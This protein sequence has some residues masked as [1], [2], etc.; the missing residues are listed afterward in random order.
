MCTKEMG[1]EGM[2]MT[3]GSSGMDCTMLEILGAGSASDMGRGG[4]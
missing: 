3:A 2:G 4:G 1:C